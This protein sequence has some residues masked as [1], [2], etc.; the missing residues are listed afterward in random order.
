M[1][2]LNFG[3][4]RDDNKG[5]PQ[6]GSPTGGGSGSG[7]VDPTDPTSPAQP[8]KPKPSLTQNTLNGTYLTLDGEPVLTSKKKE[9]SIV[10]ETLNI[11]HDEGELRIE[12]SDGGSDGDFTIE[13]AFLKGGSW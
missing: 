7:T 5:L 8:E 11:S 4:D 1:A 9:L 12:R 2:V 13:G 6:V 3:K 10:S